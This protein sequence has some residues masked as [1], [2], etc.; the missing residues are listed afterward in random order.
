MFDR[1]SAIARNAGQPRRRRPRLTERRGGRMC[2]PSQGARPPPGLPTSA[3]TRRDWS[4]AYLA[5]S[6]TAAPFIDDGVRRYGPRHDLSQLFARDRITCRHPRV[7]PQGDALDEASLYSP[8]DPQHHPVPMPRPTCAATRGMARSGETLGLEVRL[9]VPGD[10]RA[11]RRMGHERLSA[12]AVHRAANQLSRRNRAPSVDARYGGSDARYAYRRML[13][14]T[15]LNEDYDVYANKADQRHQSAP[16]IIDAKLAETEWVACRGPAIAAPLDACRYA[17]PGVY[18][19]LERG[20]LVVHGPAPNLGRGANPF[21]LSSCLGAARRRRGHQDRGAID[22]RRHRD[23][24]CRC[25]DFPLCHSAGRQRRGDRLSR[26]LLAPFLSARRVR[27]PTATNVAQR[28]RA[29]RRGRLARRTV[30]SM[31]RRRPCPTSPLPPDVAA[32]VYA[33]VS[34]ATARAR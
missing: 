27:S 14:A 13:Q 9:T 31:P 11:P 4:T 17:C 28:I 16:P 5:R 30:A 6:S 8:G 20:D 15:M 22:P 29:P 26:A 32:S 25:R 1:L 3:R 23:R 2:G 33:C 7:A 24:Q 12:R 18:E 21:R 10:P 34:R 19:D